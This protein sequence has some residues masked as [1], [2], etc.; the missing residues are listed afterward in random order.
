MRPISVALMLL[1]DFQLLCTKCLLV[2]ISVRCSCS[3]DLQG[4]LQRIHVLIVL[5]DDRRFGEHLSLV[6]LD[7]Q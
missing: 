6:D 7:I 1:I 5:R 3:L 4:L 2:D